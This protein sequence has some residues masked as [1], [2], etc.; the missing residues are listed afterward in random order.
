M[1]RRGAPAISFRTAKSWER[2][3]E[4]NFEK[5]RENKNTNSSGKPCAEILPPPE[6]SQQAAPEIQP[7]R[8]YNRCSNLSPKSYYCYYVFL[9]FLNKLFNYFFKNKIK[10]ECVIIKIELVY[11]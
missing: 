11:I 4:R 10:L 6:Q 5:L 9:I 3:L 2:R 7:L 1:E 8:H